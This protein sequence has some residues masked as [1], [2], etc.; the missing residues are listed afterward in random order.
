[1]TPLILIYC[2]SHNIIKKIVKLRLNALSDKKTVT[3]T[4]FRFS[5]SLG[6]SLFL[7]LSFSTFRFFFFPS[8]FSD[9]VINSSDTSSNR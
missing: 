3:L 9:N 7:S 1:M 6:I 8:R 2:I 4:F 5:E